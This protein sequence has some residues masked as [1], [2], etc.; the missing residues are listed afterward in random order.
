M[1]DKVIINKQVSILQKTGA[2][3]QVTYCMLLMQ[4]NFLFESGV[5]FLHFKNSST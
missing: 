3:G 4:L 5:F 1:G 2:S